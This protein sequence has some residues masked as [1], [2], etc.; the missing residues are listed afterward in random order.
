MALPTVVER[1]GEEAVE[2]VRQ[3]LLEL[4]A[5]HRGLGRGGEK[6]ARFEAGRRLRRN[7]RAALDDGVAD[8]VQK[9][10]ADGAA[11]RVLCEGALF[12]ARE[13]AVDVVRQTIFKIR[14]K[15]L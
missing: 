14:A 2:V 6:Y 10:V 11:K 5:R 15:H 1:G 12:V 3:V 9:L 7:V 8:F 13:R 4:V